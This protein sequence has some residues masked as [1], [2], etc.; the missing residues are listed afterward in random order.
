MIYITSY[1]WCCSWWIPNHEWYLFKLMFKWCCNAF[2]YLWCHFALCWQKKESIRGTHQK[3]TPPA[4][5]ELPELS[6]YNTWNIFLLLINFCIRHKNRYPVIIIICTYFYPIAVF[7]KNTHVSK[8]TTSW[9]LGMPELTLLSCHS[10]A[11]TVIII[12][13]C[14][15]INFC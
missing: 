11:W 7:A 12:Y 10:A 6:H 1:T 13:L 2:L 14:I 5:R 4:N 3:K 8:L 9:L 15:I